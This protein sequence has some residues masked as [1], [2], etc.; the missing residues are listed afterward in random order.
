MSIEKIEIS[1]IIQVKPG[2]PHSFKIGVVTEID[3][4]GNLGICSGDK[5]FEILE[6]KFAYWVGRIHYPLTNWPAA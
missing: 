2:H 3:I 4:N 5:G 6:S 1:D